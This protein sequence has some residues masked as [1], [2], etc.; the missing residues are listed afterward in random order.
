MRVPIE[1]LAYGKGMLLEAEMLNRDFALAP[2]LV[3]NLT[4]RYS[5]GILGGLT[6]L[7][8]DQKLY[9]TPG[10]F[11]LG[12]RLGWSRTELALE[13]PPLGETR[14]LRVDAGEDAWLLSWSPDE[15]AGLILCRLTPRDP[16]LLRDSFHLGHKEDAASQNWLNY[17]DAPD[18][19]QLEYARGASLS[20]RPTLLP[21]LQRRLLPFVQDEGFKLWLLNGIFPLL[22]YFGTDDWSAAL[23]R[24]A[25][26]LGFKKKK[27][28][29]P[30]ERRSII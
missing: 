1:K 16:K 29:S 9:L 7:V 8:R 27:T 25:E 19:I 26:I 12:G 23:D 14:F 18:Y 2:F 28:R 21:S 10:L 22:D 4:D 30:D 3:A 6:V 15:R 24:F 20:A 11:K 5:D 17:L 13:T